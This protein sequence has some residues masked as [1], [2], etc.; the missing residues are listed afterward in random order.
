[1]P[2]SLALRSGEW[3]RAGQARARAWLTRPS[4]LI[5]LGL[6]AAGV[7]P[8]L[9][10][11]VL[12]DGLAL[13]AAPRFGIVLV[14]SLIFAPAIAAAAITLQGFGIVLSRLRAEA[15]T[16]YRQAIGRVLLGAL[17][18][19]W[20]FGLWARSPAGL[21]AVQCILVAS[22]NLGAAWL[23]LLYLMFDP[24]RAPMVRHVALVADM[25]LLSL[26]L[27]AGGVSTAALAPIYL[28]VAT[29][30]ADQHGPREQAVAIGLGV[31]LFAAV[32]AVTPYWRGQLLSAA[33][34]L[35]AV[36]LLPT[37]VGARLRRLE[38]GRTR[39][40]IANA[41]KDRFLLILDE[42]LRGPLRTIARAGTGVDRGATDSNQGDALAR[43]RLNARIMLLELDD[44]LNSVKLGVGASGPESRTFDLYRLANGA[45]AALRAAASECGALLDLRIDP[46]LPYQLYGWPHQLRQVLIGLAT[47]ALRDAGKAKVRI[48]LGAAD[49]GPQTVILRVAVSTTLGDGSLGADDTL[50][51][52]G[53]RPPLGLAVVERVVEAMGGRLIVD[54]GQGRDISLTAELPFAI[55]QAFLLRPLDLAGLPVL[56]V[57][58]DAQ[59]AD[60]LIEPLEAWR[61]EPRWIGAEAAALDYLDA[62]ESGARRALLIVDGRADVLRSLSWAHRAV[63]LCAPEPP[64]IL[65]IADE[66]RIDSIIGLADGELDVILPAPL[67]PDV[68]RSAL[69]SLMIEPAEELSAGLQ[70]PSLPRLPRRSIVNEPSGDEPADAAPLRERE[71]ALA[72]RQD[73][74]AKRSWQVLVATGNVSNRRIIAS[75]LSGSGHTVHLAA[76]ADEARR[77]LEAQEIDVLLLDLAGTRSADYEAA[78]MCRRARPGVI[79]IALTTAPAEEAE[80]WAREIG[81]DAVLR[82]PVRTRPLLAAIEA[83][84]AGK[85]VEPRAA[86]AV[87]DLSSHPRFA[88]D[89]APPERPVGIKPLRQ[90]NAFFGGAIENFRTD[91][92]RIIADLGQAAR[93]G[94]AH[95]FESGL[96][97]LRNSTANLDANRL[98]ELTQSMR[99]LSAAVLRQQGSDYVQRL[100]A[101][102]RRLDAV[103]VERQRTAN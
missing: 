42:D 67:T 41:A 48:D 50:A 57:S 55:D 9:V 80:R 61:G 96:Q 63:A 13:L 58:H 82:K 84:V 74:P 22:L 99:G 4:F 16:A 21:A 35:A 49:F 10:L 53:A 6:G 91:G 19:G 30:Y 17:V 68:L 88:A 97:S 87:T 39:A 78:R 2:R 70:S 12:P 46:K 3:S 25:A 89:P 75:L 28:Y 59:L 92:R 100:D 72:P 73:A 85:T 93:A 26:L 65:F 20:V 76:G 44:A 29:G 62:F 7:F 77:K 36:I 47:N 52:D 33:G 60:E 34:V 14:A 43:V 5:A 79:I 23:F 11:A 102:L 27:A 40:E 98:R 71:I 24:A 32:V 86:S 56:I 15:D 64:H 45:V 94:D 66:A 103:L 51:S 31:F 18:F 1:M 101:E 90:S 95:A 83:A 69:H 37:Y 81:L 8:P 38:E 54:V